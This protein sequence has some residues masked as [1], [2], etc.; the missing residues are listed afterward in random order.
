[1]SLRPGAHGNIA[2]EELVSHLHRGGI[3]TGIDLDALTDVAALVRGIVASAR[4]LD[5]VH[6][7]G[8]NEA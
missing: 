1:M 7:G 6:T 3:T 5:T 2:T 8:R 4:P